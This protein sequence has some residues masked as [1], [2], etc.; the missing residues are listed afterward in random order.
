LGRI[1]LLFPRFTFNGESRCLDCVAFNCVCNSHD[2]KGFEDIQYSCVLEEIQYRIL[3]GRE[4]KSIAVIKRNNKKMTVVAWITLIFGLYLVSKDSAFL[5]LLGI[6]ATV[7]S[8][9]LYL[10]YGLKE[11][12]EQG[13]ICV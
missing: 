6:V 10:K 5:I 1:D 7:T 13:S 11:F 4:G 2:L 8:V 12:K 3:Y 9:I